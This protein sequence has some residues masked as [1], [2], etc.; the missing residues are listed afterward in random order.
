[1]FASEGSKVQVKVPANWKKLVT[2]VL[3]RLKPI[4][5][6]YNHLESEIIKIDDFSNENIEKL[7]IEQEDFVNKEF[8][9]TQEES[10]SLDYFKDNYAYVTDGLIFNIVY[11]FVSDLCVYNEIYGNSWLLGHLST[12]FL[13]PDDGV[14]GKRIKE[15]GSPVAYLK[16]VCLSLPDN[17]EEYLARL[18]NLRELNDE[19]QR[20]EIEIF[21]EPKSTYDDEVLKENLSDKAYNGY[22]SQ[23][24]K[25]IEYLKDKNKSRLEK[26]SQNFEKDIFLNEPSDREENFSDQLKS[27]ENN[28]TNFKINNYSVIVQILGP[29][30]LLSFGHARVGMLCGDSLKWFGFNPSGVKEEFD[31]LGRKNVKK[32]ITIISEQYER[33]YE[34]IKSYSEV[35]SATTNNCIMF[36]DRVLEVCKLST[37]CRDLF[38]FEEMREIGVSEWFVSYCKYIEP[39]SQEKH[40][41]ENLTRNLKNAFNF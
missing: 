35:Y 6:R 8:L 34:F 30:G 15:L 23:T 40:N 24:A 31:D 14:H 28:F 38:S 22:V 27:L 25:Y 12:E 33:A 29:N 19:A 16:E 13:Y 26:D 10:E 3:D 2:G 20:L 9:V 36:A 41:I 21:G 1:M 11:N 18:D 39:L 7:R 17:Y 5:D 32:S 37:R 4:S